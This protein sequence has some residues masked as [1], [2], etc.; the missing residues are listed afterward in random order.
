MPLK[1]FHPFIGAAA[2]G[3]DRGTSGTGNLNDAVF[4]HQLDKVFHFFGM[5]GDF[6]HKFF[7]L[8]VCDFCI[9][10]FHKTEDF[11]A[12]FMGRF[13][14]DKIAEMVR[15]YETALSNWREVREQITQMLPKEKQ[16][17]YREITKQM[18]TRLYNDLVDL[19]E[20]RY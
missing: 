13:D 16:K 10:N 8:N 7:R 18:H 9:E 1:C 20:I 19:K 6:N 15:Y 2:F 3:R 4:F 17:S 14:F 5:S 11:R 12:F